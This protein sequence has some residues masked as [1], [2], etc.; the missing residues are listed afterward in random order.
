MPHSIET[1]TGKVRKCNTDLDPGWTLYDDD[2][3]EK[4]FVRH[5]EKNK[6]MDILVFDA[7]RGYGEM[8][9]DDPEYNEAMIATD[10]YPCGDLDLDNP[11]VRR[12][13]EGISFSPTDDEGN[14]FDESIAMSMF[15]YGYNY[16]SQE[17]LALFDDFDKV[18]SLNEKQLDNAWECGIDRMNCSL[19]D[20]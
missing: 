11:K 5:D 16:S 18:D 9:K 17:Y 2:D 20:L 6:A 3:E 1:P 12:S 15:R 13:I 8:E 7:K 14:P 19:D 4:V 10:S